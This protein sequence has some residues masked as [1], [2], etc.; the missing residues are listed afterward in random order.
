MI[1][2]EQQISYFGNSDFLFNYEF[3]PTQEP[4][5]FDW[6]NDKFDFL[7]YVKTEFQEESNK[8]KAS[9]QSSSSQCGSV[10]NESNNGEKTVHCSTA[11]DVSN[12]NDIQNLF[13]GN[14][15][16]LNALAILIRNQ[17]DEKGVNF[18]VEKCLD[19]EYVDEPQPILRKLQRK[20]PLQKCE[21]KRAYETTSEWYIEYEEKLG[22]R[23][24][25]TRNQVH[26]WHFDERKRRETNQASLNKRQKTQE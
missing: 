17:T 12:H 5:E 6:N 8:L 15:V 16:N 25:L 23:I 24:G 9:T 10:K 26:K 19:L 4:E 11:D 21:L 3:N 13:S 2:Q 22:K 7:K 14:E 18:M 20:T 1:S